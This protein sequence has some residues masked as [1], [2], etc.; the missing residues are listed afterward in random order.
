MKALHRTVAGGAFG[1]LTA[2]TVAASA[3]YACHPTS[4][5]ELN[6]A[7]GQPG[8]VVRVEGTGFE[9]GRALDVRW[10]ANDGRTLGSSPVRAVDMTGS[11]QAMLR[12]TIPADAAPSSK[13]YVLV[14]IQT[15]DDGTVNR[16]VKTFT[17]T[18]PAAAGPLSVATSPEPSEMTLAPSTA[19]PVAPVGAP[20]PA[21]QP[22]PEP[23]PEGVQTSAPAALASAPAA[24][25]PAGAAVAPEARPAT[26]A[27][28]VAP[29]PATAS[30]SPERAAAPAS[31]DLWSAVGPERASGLLDAPA[32]AS[33]D[34]S[35]PV[36]AILVGFGILAMAG[37]ALSA[38]RSRLALASRI[39]TRR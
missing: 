12:V 31:D 2:A 10:N 37:V 13:P 6:V 34:A 5:I 4:Y 26:E 15:L 21:S 3:A 14:A 7:Q 33:Q 22:A 11:P 19:A 20:V 38:G 27:A 17:V 9:P 16:A 39:A 29:V 35:V 32:A 28:S 36:G 24:L 1:V 30:L 8:A 18:A 23:A 25:V